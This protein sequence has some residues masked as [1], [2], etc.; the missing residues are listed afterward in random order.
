MKT[1]PV[2][3]TPE[4]ASYI[5]LRARLTGYTDSEF[6]ATIIDYWFTQ[7][8]PPV[9]DEEKHITAGKRLPQYAYIPSDA[10]ASLPKPPLPRQITTPIHIRAAQAKYP[11]NPTCPHCQIPM[12][13]FQRIEIPGI[14]HLWEC[15]KC[16]FSVDDTNE[17]P[18]PANPSTSIPNSTRGSRT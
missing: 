8:C 9:T 13:R 10:V 17:S 16:H 1:L 3:L 2:L 7:E 18:Q 15:P 14:P 11:N 5:S 4:R 12:L 6:I